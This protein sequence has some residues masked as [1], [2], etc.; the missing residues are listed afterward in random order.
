MA[1]STKTKKKAVETPIDERE[2]FVSLQKTFADTE[3]SVHDKLKILYQLQAADNAIEKLV[4]L[5]G[6]LP[7]EVAALENEIAG[8]QG[9]I[10]HLKEVIEEYHNSIEANKHQIVELDGEIDKYQKQ[11]ENISNSREYDSINKELE[12][13]GLLRQIAEKN[14]NEARYAIEDRK[15]DIEAI[16]DRITIREEDL[17][18]KQEELATIVEST[19]KEET[20][21]SHQREAC[22]AQIDARTMSA[23]ERIRASKHNHLA[24]VAVKNGDSCGGCLNSITPQRLIDIASGKRLVICEHCG[25]IIV[26]PE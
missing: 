1:T 14:I 19:A 25:R 8:F 4:Q 11:L 9:K 5:R 24:V 18:A 17:K 15:R 26:N 2:T 20:E 16:T 6:E 12:N 10:A 22:A 23:Y 13:L 7:G 21:L 3:T